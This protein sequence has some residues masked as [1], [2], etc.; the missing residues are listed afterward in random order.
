MSFG[1]AL[2]SY[3]VGNMKAAPL[4]NTRGETGRYHFVKR[5]ETWLSW[6]LNSV[7]SQ[8]VQNITETF[9]ESTLCKM[10]LIYI[11]CVPLQ[12]EWQVNRSNIQF[13]LFFPSLIFVL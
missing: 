12:M 2:S 10:R 11:S 4:A 6:R 7:E 5:A 9:R 8:I 3:R 13:S 1:E